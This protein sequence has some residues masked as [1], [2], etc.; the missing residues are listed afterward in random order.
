MEKSGVAFV[1]IDIAKLKNM[2]AATESRRTPRC[3]PLSRLIGGGDREHLALAPHPVAF[4]MH[5][6]R[7]TMPHGAGGAQLDN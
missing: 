2:I 7:C 6:I 1:G 4:Q 5:D 3:P